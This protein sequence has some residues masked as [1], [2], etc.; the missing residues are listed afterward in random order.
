[1]TAETI[2][3]YPFDHAGLGETSLM[4]AFCPEVVDMERASHKS[5]YT[6]D[7]KDANMELG[8]KGGDLILAN[9]RRALKQRADNSRA[10]QLPMK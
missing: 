6:S 5:W 7:A 1:M 2:K 9:M 4:L 8:V 10:R 3:E